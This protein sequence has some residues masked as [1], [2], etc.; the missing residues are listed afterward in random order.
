M[1]CYAKGIYGLMKA[2]CKENILFY[3]NLCI[4][5]TNVDETF[6]QFLTQK[7]ILYTGT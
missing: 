7:A 1:L 5:S 3:I 2:I 4:T 6:L